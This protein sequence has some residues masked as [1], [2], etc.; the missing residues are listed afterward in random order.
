VAVESTQN[1]GSEPPPPA[2]LDITAGAG[3]GA[4]AVPV[5]KSPSAV[6]NDKAEPL[7]QNAK[8]TRPALV[9]VTFSQRDDRD[10]CL[11]RNSGIRTYFQR[12]CTWCKVPQYKFSALSIRAAKEPT[13]IIWANQSATATSKIARRAVTIL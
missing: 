5:P 11:E 4:G 6:N 10:Q 13:D 8:H 7:L 2:Y 1:I 3:A 9:L 12:C